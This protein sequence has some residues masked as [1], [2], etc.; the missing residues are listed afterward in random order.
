MQGTMR[1]LAAALLLAAAAPMPAQQGV[2]ALPVEFRGAWVATVDNI[3]WPSRPGLPVAQMRAELDAILDR[4]AELHLNALVFQVRTECDA[5]YQSAIEPWS[6]WLTG[7]Q[8]VAPAEGF[9]P[10]AHAVAG[11]HRRGMEL[12]AWFNPYRARHFK[13]KSAADPRHVSVAN[14]AWVVQYGEYKWMDPGVPEALEHTLAVVLDVVR[15]YDIDGVHIDD[16]FYPY[17][18]KGL[19]FPDGASHAA[20]RAR[21]GTLPVADWRRRNV[22]EM[23]R[24]LHQQ[25]HREKPWMKFGI[26]PF[27]VAR[28]GVPEGTTAGIDQFHQLH[29]DVRRWLREGW[30]DYIAPQLYWPIDQKPQSFAVLLPWW[31]REVGPECHLWTGINPGRAAAR[32]K[33]WREG[34]LATQVLLMRQQPRATGHVHFSFKSLQ[35]DAGGVAT[36]LR[37]GVYAKRAAIP[38]SPWLSEGQPRPPEARIERKAT[39][40][41]LAWQPSP[42]ARFV[43]VQARAGD[44][45]ELVAT[46]DATDL[47]AVLPAGLTTGEMAIRV[48]DRAAVASEPVVLRV[49]D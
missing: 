20:Y 12:H 40:L 30:C 31:A 38:P 19:D 35:R 41:E 37:S 48:L 23:V 32:E 13:S 1:C 18:V 3:D 44:T 47:R 5:L 16:Y 28:P 29:A 10:L 33:H 21:G 45:W 49:A 7:Q 26:S 4:A 24:R 6:E 9:D 14:P 17:P 25:V 22:D 11:A 2:P 15:R 27:G 8:G 36:L 42:G 46:C 43:T 39:G 34:E